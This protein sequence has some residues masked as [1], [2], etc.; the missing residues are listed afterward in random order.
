MSMGQF[1]AVL[2]FGGLAVL[3]ALFMSIGL[4]K[5]SQKSD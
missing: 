2:G 3:L 1:L 5:L 4:L